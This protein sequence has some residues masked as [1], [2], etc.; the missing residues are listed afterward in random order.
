MIKKNLANIIT[1]SR[2][3]GT[4]VL[5]FFDILSTPFKCIYAWCGLSDILDG[6]VARTFKTSS[7]LGS[8]LDSFSDL[9]L[10]I[11]MLYKIWPYLLRDF[12]PYVMILIVGAIIIRGLCYLYV[13]NKSKTLESRHTMLN[14][15]TSFL[16]FFLP[17]TVDTGYMLPYALL[18][19]TVGYISNIEE[20][21][22]LIKNN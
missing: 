22:Y 5:I 11:V 15:I 9:S 13:G 17:F 18:I 16:L 14:K 4:F 12:P 1:L 20:I 10:Y 6:F 8:K 19:L 7:E 2:I 21:I 3:V